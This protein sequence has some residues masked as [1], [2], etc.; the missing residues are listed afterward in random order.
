MASK[1]D[2]LQAHRF[3][4]QRVLSA[5]VT[6]ETDPEQP[7]F[8]RPSGAVWGSIAIA[9]VTLTAVGVYG[10]VV[11]GGNRAWRDGAAVIVV[12][13][14]G[15]R[16]VYVDGRLH[17]VL[18]YASALLVLGRNAPTR[19]VS[20]E[21]LVGVPRGPRI[22]IPDAPDALPRA[23]RVST[24]GWTLCS[25]PAPDETGG[26]V[27][28]SVLLAGAEPTGG[29]TLDEA[30]LL[31]EVPETGDQYLIWRGYRHRIRQPDTVTV[32]LALRA[33]P[34]TRVGLAVVDVLPAGEPIA[35]IP[36]PQA[37]RP[38]TA[39][40]R[41]PELRTG[42]L[43]RVQTSGG[44]VQHYLVERDRLRLISELQYDIQLA[45]RE[46]VAAYRGGEPIG[47]PLGLVAATEARQEVPPTPGPDAAPPRRPDFAEPGPGPVTVC[48]TYD[49]G[50]WVPRLRV[51]A[52]LPAPEAM[53]ATAG[54]TAE[55]LPLADLVYVPPGRAALVEVMPSVTARSGTV[56]L[57]TELGRAYPLAGREVLRILGYDRVTPVR[58]PAGLVARVPLG[59]GLDPL[60]ARVG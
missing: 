51:G 37:G 28:R 13:E 5:L 23:D 36:V 12:K 9:A 2:L 56:L 48:A 14:T 55:G 4:T 31:V 57:V 41:R 35:P 17:P 53:T 8:R 21:S 10:L 18:N 45:H 24:A 22:G 50:R 38:S 1:R 46:T 40:P 26:T 52:A 30:A 49:D 60:A 16:Y 34:R 59:S 54:R 19:T 6:R 27:D 25:R 42:Q 47:L 33:A 7:P 44:G 39:V 15:T 58:L 32:G 11:P 29:R 3:L 43:L 20:R